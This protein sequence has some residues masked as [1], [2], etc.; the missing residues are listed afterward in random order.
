MRGCYHQAHHHQ[1]L[2][3]TE[4]KSEKSILYSI[5]LQI[6]APL[7][8]FQVFF[9]P[10]RV[11]YRGAEVVAN[12]VGRSVGR[13]LARSLAYPVCVVSATMTVALSWCS[14]IRTYLKS[15]KSSKL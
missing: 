8:L 2:L 5:G 3:P 6:Q 9:S 14:I 13:L 12:S 11:R 10:F 1:Q 4:D 15:A 7:N